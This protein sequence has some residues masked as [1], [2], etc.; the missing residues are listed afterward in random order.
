MVSRHIDYADSSRMQIPTYRLSCKDSSA[1][2]AVSWLSN[3]ACCSC[4]SHRPGFTRSVIRSPFSQSCSM[5]NWSQ[6]LTTSDHIA[7]NLLL[8]SPPYRPSSSLSHPAIFPPSRQN[9]SAGSSRM[10]LQSPRALRSACS[11]TA[12][13]SSRCAGRRRGACAFSAKEFC[14]H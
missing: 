3:H 7:S 6:Y 13:S 12:R 14:A 5:S 8:P 11:S 2:R 1:F 10:D 4:S 9:T